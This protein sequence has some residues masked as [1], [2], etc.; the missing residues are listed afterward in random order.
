MSH[1]FISYARKD[2]MF[3][4]KVVQAL[5][6]KKV[7]TWKDW[8][9]IPP[10]EDW[11]DEIYRGIEDA[12]VFLFLISPNSVRSEM[13][14]KEIEHAIRN[15]KRIVTILIHDTGT[16][17]ILPHLSKIQWIACRDGQDDFDKAIEAIRITIHTDYEWLKYHTAMQ[18]KALNWKQHADPS[19]LL[20]EKELR[21]AEEQFSEAGQKDPQP[22]DLQRQY[23]L[24]SRRRETRTRNIL[25][26][27]S[28]VAIATLIFLAVFARTQ[29]NIA[30]D[31]A[32]TAVANQNVAQTAQADAEEQT[33]IARSGELAAA[34][35]SNLDTDPERSILLSMQAIRVI[36]AEGEA[37]P[38]AVDALQRSL[39]TSRVQLTIP[40]YEKQGTGDTTEILNIHKFC[41]FVDSHDANRTAARRGRGRIRVG[42]KRCRRQ[43]RWD[44]SGRLRSC[45]TRREGGERSGAR[46]GRDGERSKR[47]PAK[48]EQRGWGC[49]GPDR[50]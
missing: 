29:Q 31:N 8:E 48:A 10:A 42:G 18:R 14:K 7:D 11:E 9:N 39:H 12:D 34:A 47:R 33:K 21:E 26:G 5:A 36:N 37:L 32:L 41:G 46:Q 40:I 43:S 15:G 27:I 20:R 24:E 35:I 23:L 22:T 30:D 25:L 4:K 49:H 6:D 1:I 17:N 13:C 50:R 44:L 28:A 2:I 3:A 45:R 38:E 16:A 19:R